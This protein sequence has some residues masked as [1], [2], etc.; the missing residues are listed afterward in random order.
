MPSTLKV[1]CKKCGKVLKTPAKN[2]GK[3][4]E[5]PKCK[6]TLMIPGEEQF[7][8][9]KSERAVIEEARISIDHNHESEPSDA[10][11]LFQILYTEA[12]PVKFALARKNQVPLL[13][14]SNGGIGFAVKSTKEN[15]K[16]SK[17][18]IIEIEIDFPILIKPVRLSVE[19]RWRKKMD[20]KKIF[21]LGVKFHKPS[22]SILRTINKL[23]D[24]IL[25]RPEVWQLE[26]K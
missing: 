25:T 1:R 6:N 14:L 23:I 15:A 3:K 13:D 12:D 2:A 5:C 16:L 4:G 11:V 10:P 24:Y 20:N 21:Q 18:Q 9:R 8:K 26:E 22:K 19:I 7:K 17:G